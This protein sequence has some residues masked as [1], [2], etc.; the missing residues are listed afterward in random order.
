MTLAGRWCGA[1][2]VAKAET[3]GGRHPSPLATVVGTTSRVIPRC[4]P[5]DRCADHW[6]C[7][8]PPRPLRTP[9]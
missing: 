1:L 9:S 7:S 4:P 2:V 6:R 3:E 8:Q 5:P